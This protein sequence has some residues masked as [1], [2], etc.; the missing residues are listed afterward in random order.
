MEESQGGSFNDKKGTESSESRIS[1]RISRQASDL[2]FVKTIS[3]RESA[4]NRPKLESAA[5]SFSSLQGREDRHPS[6]SLRVWSSLC[7]CHVI[8]NSIENVLGE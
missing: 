5:K 8:P 4:A 3:Q 7:L 6:S 2:W 1:I